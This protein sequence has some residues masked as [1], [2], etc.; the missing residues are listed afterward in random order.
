M[1][2]Q[3][4]LGDA[5]YLD[6]VDLSGD[7][8]SV[9]RLANP[10]ALLDVTA[11]D[12]S[13]MERIYGHYDGEISFNTWFNDIVGGSFQIL[14]DKNAGADVIATYFHGATIGN[15][16]AGLVAKQ[17]NF[18]WTRAQ[19]GSLEATIQLLGNGYGL[20]YGLQLTAGKR[21][22]TAATNGASLNFGA[23]TALGLAAYL[24]VFSLGSGTPTIKIQESSNDGGGDPFADVVGGTF[25][26]ITAPMGQR[27]VTSLTLPVEQY[28]R[29]VTT[30]TFANL[31]FAVAITRFP[32]A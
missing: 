16:A 12:K 4:G 2:K 13:A 22:D 29:V 19:D 25:G 18:D 1:A 24:E 20:D 26:A 11:L 28:L 7:V 31:V 27:I 5:L 8:G 17:V 9:A 15:M 14:K 21:T 32:Y 3:S 23:A 30:G 10:S 6:G